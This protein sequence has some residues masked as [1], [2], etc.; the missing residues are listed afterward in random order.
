MKKAVM[1]LVACCALGAALISFSRPAEKTGTVPDPQERG[2]C[3]F[4]HCSHEA[5]L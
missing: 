3:Y 1:F 2:I 4:G 5:D